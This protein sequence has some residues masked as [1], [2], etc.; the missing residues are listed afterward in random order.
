M[1]R[2]V[3]KWVQS[4]D[5]SSPIR[6]PKRDLANGVLVAEILSRYCHGRGADNDGGSPRV[7]FSMAGILTGS[8]AE[9]RRHNWSL[10]LRILQELKCGTVTAPLVEA[11]LRLQPHSAQVVLDNLYMFFTQHTLPTASL[12]LDRAAKGIR[13]GPEEVLTFEEEG[14]PD[15]KLMGAAQEASPFRQMEGPASRPLLEVV[16]SD[17]GDRSADD[18]PRATGDHFKLSKA[19]GKPAHCLKELLGFTDNVEL[20]A[21]AA[22]VSQP[23][24]TLHTASTLLRIANDDR[25][26]VALDRVKY[27]EDE[28]T[29][30]LRNRK[31]IKQHE[32]FNRLIRTADMASQGKRQGLATNVQ[33]GRGAPSTTGIS[34]AKRIRGRFFLNS[35]KPSDR[36]RPNGI[37]AVDPSHSPP[38]SPAPLKHAEGG[39]RG[40]TIA[41][42]TEEESIALFEGYL[43]SLREGMS[44]VLRDV[45]KAHGVLDLL[46]SLS[47]INVDTQ[48]ESTRYDLFTALVANRQGLPPDTLRDCWTMLGIHASGIAAAIHARPDQYS[49]L[50]QALRFMFSTESAKVSLLH[51]STGET[52]NL[53]NTPD[54]K[55]PSLSQSQ[56]S[57]GPQSAES[58]NRE[59]VNPTD[60]TAKTTPSVPEDLPSRGNLVK[61]IADALLGFMD[62][63]LTNDS[64]RHRAVCA[65]NR[66]FH[67]VNCLIFLCRVGR[68]LATGWWENL[69]GDEAAEYEAVYFPSED[70]IP[71]DVMASYFL[72]ASRRGLLEEG[73]PAIVEAVARVL[74]ATLSVHDKPEESSL[75]EMVGQGSPTMRSIVNGFDSRNAKKFYFVTR[76]LGF[77]EQHITPAFDCGVGVPSRA[78][79]D[80]VSINRPF[81]VRKNYFRFSLTVYHILRRLLQTGFEVITE[82]GYDAELVQLKECI[83]SFAFN[84]LSG[85]TLDQRCVGVAFL[86]LLVSVRPWVEEAFSMENLSGSPTFPSSVLWTFVQPFMRVSKHSAT[87]HDAVL[88]ETYLAPTLH[89]WELRVLTLEFFSLL[90]IQVAYVFP[91]EHQPTSHGGFPSSPVSLSEREGGPKLPSGFFTPADLPLAL[92]DTVVKTLRSFTKD[93]KPHRQ[94]ALSIVGRH[95]LPDV[96]PRIAGAWLKLLVGMTPK[97][98]IRALLPLGDPLLRLNIPRGSAQLLLSSETWHEGGNG[99]TDKESQ[100]SLE[101]LAGAPSIVM[102][103]GRIEPCYAVMPLNQTW[104]VGAVVH[105]VLQQLLRPPPRKGLNAEWRCATPFQL[106]Q[107]IAAAAMSPQDNEL[108][109]R[110]L[111]RDL[112]LIDLFTRPLGGVAPSLEVEQKQTPNEGSTKLAHGDP[113]EENEQEGLE[114]TETDEGEAEI[115]LTLRSLVQTASL[116]DLTMTNGEGNSFKWSTSTL[117]PLKSTVKDVD[118]SGSVDASG[119]KAQFSIFHDDKQKE[120]D[121]KH[122]TAAFW[123]SSLRHLVPFFAYLLQLDNF[124]AL[125]YFPW[126]R[127]G[128]EETRGEEVDQKIITAVLLAIV[129]KILPSVNVG[130]RMRGLDEEHNDREVCQQILS[131][132][133]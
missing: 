43:W 106:L 17:M 121:V 125:K 3:I 13:G 20:A 76:I 40:A 24:Y 54:P 105:I 41:K 78:A 18:A 69:Q 8:S 60:P 35:R 82:R 133:L 58:L 131:W 71:I 91:S 112:N 2:E 96:H 64:M 68:A 67:L 73:T 81:A 84:A 128:G 53:L 129:H 93:P 120:W 130:D 22:G 11:V 7:A 63:D 57:D 107:I 31:I 101:T 122:V 80:T 56:K 10:I 99:P 49:Y 36:P 83:S 62:S 72:P 15:A 132:F 116:P 46:A 103:Y 119:G 77:I 124:P 92:Q 29:S 27:V 113:G 48:D 110:Q 4:L 98:F 66:A 50:L 94:L 42:C 123:S 25:N 127:E 115:S 117:M 37:G 28:H 19:S 30:Y 52:P 38:L 51:V 61:R 104:N 95:L 33:G 79:C 12:G 65:N 74:V 6:N 86:I 88:V 89:T 111:L 21:G 5:L 126:S 16:M 114:K 85:E 90:S 9:S 109:G 34:L 23:S 108:Q 97:A 26:Q 32:A 75:P 45:L 102:L 1:Q 55:S 59:E 100:A 118:P 39:V 87:P 70:D 47:D 14:E 44:Y